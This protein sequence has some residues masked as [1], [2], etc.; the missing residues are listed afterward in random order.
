MAKPKNII[1]HGRINNRE[2]LKMTMFYANIANMQMDALQLTEEQRM[3]FKKI[4]YESI[5][6]KPRVDK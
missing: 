5:Q 3:Q 1:V 2:K 4:L 6:L